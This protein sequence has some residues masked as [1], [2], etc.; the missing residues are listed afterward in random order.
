MAIP[1]IT[2]DE[3]F[4]VLVEDELG[5]SDGDWPGDDPIEL[6]QAVLKIARLKAGALFA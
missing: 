1:D 4:V 2:V 5:L 6:C 3:E